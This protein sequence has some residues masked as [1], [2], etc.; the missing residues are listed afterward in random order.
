MDQADILIA[1]GA[2]FMSGITAAA[3]KEGSPSAKDR[4]HRREQDERRRALAE[5][6]QRVRELEMTGGYRSQPNA[7]IEALRQHAEHLE[8]WI[9]N[10]DYE[11]QHG[12]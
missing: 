3:V 11:W 2:L 1:I 6:E 12:W 5:I 9:A 10:S 7:E 8:R 4:A